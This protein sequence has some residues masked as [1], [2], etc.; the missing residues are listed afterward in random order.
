MAHF[1]RILVLMLAVLACAE[2]RTLGKYER[3]T[4]PAGPAE[5]FPNPLSPEDAKE[6][7]SQ[8]RAHAAH[9]NNAVMPDT[10]EPK[11]HE[12]PP[13]Y[14]VMGDAM[15]KE[16]YWCHKNDKISTMADFQREKSMDPT[17]VNLVKDD[18]GFREHSTSENIDAARAE[19]KAND[20]RNRA[21]SLKM[22]ILGQTKTEEVIAD[23]N[24]KMAMAKDEDTK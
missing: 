9:R 5:D 4:D 19:A 1:T 15:G 16:K 21:E 23:A 2:T 18:L 7:V 24:V 12:C 8:A 6:L 3:A 22:E 20:E 11:N 10:V 13:G 14:H 17:G